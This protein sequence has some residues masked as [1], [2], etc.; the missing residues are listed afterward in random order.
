MY[1]LTNFFNILSFF[2]ML[3][4]CYDQNMSFIDK[5][6]HSSFQNGLAFDLTMYIY[7]STTQNVKVVD[8]KTSIFVK[9]AI[10]REK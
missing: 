10:V 6:N 7:N 5:C 4:I 1:F 3:F 2:D 8:Q 9:N